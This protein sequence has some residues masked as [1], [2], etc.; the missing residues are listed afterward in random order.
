MLPSWPGSIEDCASVSAPAESALA[1][2]GLNMLG[3]GIA[4]LTGETPLE[5]DKCLLRKDSSVDVSTPGYRVLILRASRV[6]RVPIENEDLTAGVTPDCG[7]ECLRQI[8]WG[9]FS[10]VRTVAVFFDFERISFSK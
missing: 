2:A 6:V 1:G 5:S 9:S 7:L 3:R 4:L 8:G 10:G